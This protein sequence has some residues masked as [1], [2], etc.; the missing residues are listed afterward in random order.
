MGHNIE[1]SEDVVLRNEVLSVDVAIHV[2]VAAM[3]MICCIS[4]S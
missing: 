2:H 1:L 3:K 4:T